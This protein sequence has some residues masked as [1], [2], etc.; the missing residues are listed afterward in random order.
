M[1]LIHI[2]IFT[3]AKLIIKQ[4]HFAV[5]SQV[6]VSSTLG[7]L[8]KLN[9]ITSQNLST[10]VLYLWKNFL[11]C[12][13]V[14][15]LNNDLLLIYN[16]AFLSALFW[17]YYACLNSVLLLLGNIENHAVPACFSLMFLYEVLFLYLRDHLMFVLNVKGC[18]LFKFLALWIE[19]PFS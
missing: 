14:I 6:I 16:I 15:K 13:F 10:S 8:C 12:F 9:Q 4:Y 17:Q 2:W 11:W 5:S 1:D 7:H 3:A 18:F 19:T